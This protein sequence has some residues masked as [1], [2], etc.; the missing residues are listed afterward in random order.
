MRVTVFPWLG[1]E[2]VAISAEG[3]RGLAADAAARELLQRF[4]A[5]LR[6]RELS[7]DHTVRTRLW[8]RDR[9]ARDLGSRERV[10][11]LSGK[12]RS[13]SSSFIS[14]GHFDSE[15]SVA[16]DLLAMRPSSGAVDKLLREYEPP[17][18][19][20]RYL[21]W[22]G[23]VF[24][25]GV[26]CEHGSLD[27][28]LADVLPRIGQSLVDAGSSWRKAVRM[29]CFLHRSQQLDELK[30]LLVRRLGG[31][32]PPNSEYEFVDGYSAPGKLIEVEVTAS[33]S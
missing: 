16:L 18:V 30:G 7:I 2:F 19:P 22:E 10:A 5:E 15:A 20:L 33:A 9:E 25:S 12:A 32:L 29:S 1:K 14:P 4:D 27:D 28:Q 17:I 6:Q 21:V 23:A 24:L 3:K 31:D 11:M 26:T 8:G 13:A